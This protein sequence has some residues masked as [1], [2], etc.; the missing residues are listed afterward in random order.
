MS[1]SV[2]VIDCT[3]G[4]AATDVHIVLRYRMDSEWRDVTRGRTG[5]DGRLSL[6]TGASAE[7]GMYRLEFDLDGY[8][9]LLGIVPS[10]P[11]AI[12]E[13]RVTDRE[14]ELDMPLMMTSNSL[15]T[16]RI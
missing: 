16:Y 1:I 10:Y 2:R 7:V 14:N 11:R 9:A 8:Y 5:E 13:F 3:H 4:V 6:L 12:I 15:L